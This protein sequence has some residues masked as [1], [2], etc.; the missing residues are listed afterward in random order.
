MAI[1]SQRILHHFKD[2]CSEFATMRLPAESRPSHFIDLVSSIPLGLCLG[3]KDSSTRASGEINRVNNA[4]W[5]PATKRNLTNYTIISDK[6]AHNMVVL[7]D[8]Y[9]IFPMLGSFSFFL[10]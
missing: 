8:K 3:T 1:T 9:G 10:T 7:P 2:Y 4:N 6:G 5:N